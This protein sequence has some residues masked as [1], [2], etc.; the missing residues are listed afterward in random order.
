MTDFYICPCC[1]QLNS[2]DELLPVSVEGV[3]HWMCD[4]CA[5]IALII[6]FEPIDPLAN[7]KG[8]AQ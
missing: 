5:E 2:L 8:F 6:E 3:A 1:K 4:C 7:T